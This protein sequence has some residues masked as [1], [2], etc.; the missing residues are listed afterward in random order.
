MLIQTTLGAVRGLDLPGGITVFKGLRYAAPPVG[1]LRWKPPQ[2][3]AAWAGEHLATDFGSACLQNPSPEGS[4]YA[5]LPDR[6]SEDCLFLNVWAPKDARQAPVMVW[7]HGG[8]LRIGNLA[9][10]LYDGSELARRGVIAVTLAYRLGVLGYLAHPALSAESPQGT[11]GN[12]GLL[13]QIAALTWVREHISRFGGDPDN[14]TLFGESAG[15]LSIIELMTSPLAA[16]LFHRV[17]LQS[18]Y[19][20]SNLELSKGSHGQPAAEAVGQA[21]A[22]RLGARDL[23]TLRIMDAATLV[24]QSAALGYDPQATVDGW[25]LPRQIVDALDRG[26]QARVPMIVGFN[27]GE[28]R[29]LRLFLPPLPADEAEY[30]SLVRSRFSDLADEYLRLYPARDIEESALA[31]A[32][33]GFYGWSAERLA[34]A[35]T[36]LGVPA[37]LYFFEHRYP[38]Q[39]A[40]RLE[41]FHGSEL[42]YV[43]GRIGAAANLPPAW[44]GPPDDARE[45]AL[46]EVLMGYFTSFARAGAP[47]APG[48]PA[49]GPY[50]SYLHIRDGLSLSNDLLPGMFDL[51][52]E[53]VSRRRA[54]GTQ[55][56]YINVGLASPVV[57]PRVP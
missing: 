22:G 28:T 44:P 18:G 54:A 7:V 5:D 4:I 52:E 12:Y 30:V 26:E 36:R 50:D 56:W 55:S 29:S 16:G 32:R 57:P 24:R 3:P 47:V 25:V 31:A 21:L 6:M 15:A 11:S 40:L 39:T 37:Y 8:S 1:G 51:H 35:Q 9:S 46:S 14:V 49:W 43:F 17:I 41:S 48:A 33:D 34:R 53:I 38:A 2:P 10:G 45:H 19:L 42:P 23:A 27:A 20:M 13:D